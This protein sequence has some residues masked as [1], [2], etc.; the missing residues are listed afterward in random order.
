MLTLAG[1]S[2]ERTDTDH[3]STRPAMLP[4]LLVSCGRHGR[5]ANARNRAGVGAV[6]GCHRRVS[7]SISIRKSSAS[8]HTGA[9]DRRVVATAP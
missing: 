8:V 7:S 4:R 2:S 9:I 3:D 1:V 6:S 5:A